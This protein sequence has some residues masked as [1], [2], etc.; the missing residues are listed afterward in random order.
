MGEGTVI[1]TPHKRLPARFAVVGMLSLVL[2]MHGVGQIVFRMPQPGEVYKEYIRFNNNY[3]DEWR[4]TDPNI[5]LNQYPQAAPFLPNPT[6]SI[7]IDDLQYAIRAEVLLMLWQGHVGTTS[8][9]IRFNGNTPIPI[10]EFNNAVNGT[11]VGVGGECYIAQSMMGLQV[12]LSHLVQG[13]NEFQA[14]SGGQTCGDFGWGQ[15]GMYATIVRIYYDPLQK[16]HPT[17]TITSPGMG[18]T[19]QDN[20]TMSAS[21]SADVDRVD[22]LAYYNGYDTDGDGVFA[23]YHHDYHYDKDDGAVS[24]KNHVGTATSAPW[25]VSW[26][27][28]LVPDQPLGGIKV[29]ARVR[30]ANGVWYVTPEVS[31]VSLSRVGT[32]KRFYKP[33]NVPQSFWVQG[34]AGDTKSSNF[35]VPA[36][37]NLGDASSVTLFLRTWNG[38][39]EFAVEPGRNEHYVK[40]NSYTVDEGAYGIGHY[41]KYDKVTIPAYALTNNTN[42]VEVFANT[43]LHHGIEVLWP[44]PAVMASYTGAYASPQAVAPLLVSPADNSPSAPASPVLAWQKALTAT[45]YRL[46]VATDAGFSAIVIDDSTITDTLKQVGP[47]TGQTTYYWRV[48]TRSLAGGSGF[49]TPRSFTTFVASPTLA[50]PSNGATGVQLPPRLRWMKSTGAIGYHVQVATNSSFASGVVTNDSSLVDTT[51]VVNGLANSTTYY[52]RVKVRD[53]GAGGPFSTAWSFT[54]VIATPLA[55][56]LIGPANGTVDVPTSFIATWFKTTGASSYRI[57]VG[58]DSLFA[59]G[60]ALNDSAVTDSFRTVSGLVNDTKYYWRVNAKNAGGTGPF[61]ATWRLTTI[62]AG[63]AAPT[64]LSPANKSGNQPTSLTFSWNAASGATGYHFQL[65]SDSTFATGLVKND[66]SLATTSRS[67]VGLTPF[68]DYYWRVRARNSGGYGSYTPTWSLT[69]AMTS[70]SQVSLLLPSNG[71]VV[72][73]DTVVARW[74]KSQPSVAMYWVDHAIDS[75]F[76]FVGVDSTADTTIVF[77]QLL[78]NKTYYWRVRAR[79]IGSYGAYSATGT[80]RVL[81]TSVDRSGELPREFALSQNYPN[82]FNPSTRIEFSIPSESP[83]RLEVMNLLGERVASLVN[84]TMAAGVYAVEFDASRLSSGLYLYQLTAGTTVLTKKM[85]LLK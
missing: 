21:V 46:Q 13:Y 33:E 23:E 54:T 8:K 48:R 45:G 78:T 4:V 49:S 36:G 44:G 80:F 66:T 71:T 61:S 9:T 43:Q 69:T 35:T 39:N 15:W 22:F 73:K 16:T 19:I 67:V 27:T 14:N 20:P 38:I 68:T 51:T 47:L 63:P 56:A 42:T 65:A 24:L 50:T 11:A 58:T 82:P 10:P 81:I 57:Q 17:G 62:P 70:P 5:D 52:W 53:G 3:S 85:V 25:Q 55:T 6:L 60:V 72:S 30:G 18:G 76:T 84:Q 83:V 2:A 59:G 41:Y 64:L 40:V 32:S 7:T 74:S 26:Q 37:D 12:P 29:C 28:Q 79:N 75:L 77:R 1:A 34:Y 31:S